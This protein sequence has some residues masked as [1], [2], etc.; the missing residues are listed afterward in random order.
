MEDKY[1]EQNLPEVRMLCSREQNCDAKEQATQLPITILLY[2]QA[3]FNL[4][5][6]KKW[7]N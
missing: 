7:T 4:S 3:S 5:A 6:I 2:T 1:S